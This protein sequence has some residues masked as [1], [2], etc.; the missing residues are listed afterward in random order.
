MESAIELNI[1]RQVQAFMSKVNEFG[2]VVYTRYNEIVLDPHARSKA[3]VERIKAVCKEAGVSFELDMKTWEAYVDLG[4]HDDVYR[5]VR[6]MNDE[7]CAVPDTKAHMLLYEND[8]NIARQAMRIVHGWFDELVKGVSHTLS[9]KNLQICNC[10]STM[11]NAIQEYFARC[12]DIRFAWD[13]VFKNGSYYAF[14]TLTVVTEYES[15]IRNAIDANIGRVCRNVIE[16]M[17][18]FFASNPVRSQLFGFPHDCKP[19]M[20]EMC[21]DV[22]IKVVFEDQNVRATVN[23]RDQAKARK[24]ILDMMLGNDA[25][26]SSSIL[27]ANNRAIAK[28]ARKLVDNWCSQLQTGASYDIIIEDIPACKA[29]ADVNAA[30]EAYFKGTDNIDVTWKYSLKKHNFVQAKLEVKRVKNA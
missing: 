15:P 1:D 29:N 28:T 6:L 26:D 30:V 22:G 25:D 7:Y 17:R 19:Q 21:D 8:R 5:I 13:S 24:D 18:Q 2:S 14:G 4:H 27:C 23:I 20:Q 12:Q 16:Q 3:C 9:F 10:K 11:F